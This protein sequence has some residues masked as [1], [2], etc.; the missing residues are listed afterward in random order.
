[1]WTQQQREQRL[2]LVVNNAR[3]LILPWIKSR[4]L[5]SKVLAL[6]AK[7]LPVDWQNR[8]NYRPVLLETFVEM[9]KFAGTSY[10]AANWRCLGNTQGRGKLDTRHLKAQPIK[11]VWA[12]PLAK[13]FR[14]TLCS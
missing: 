6:T 11:S 3:F 12:Y 10:K 5:A 2:H 8:Y 1:G 14:Q 9:S 4:H 13:N 7:R